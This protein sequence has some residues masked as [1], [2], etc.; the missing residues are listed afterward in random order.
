M[1][2][3]K[4]KHPNESFESL[5][6][7]F[8]RSVERDGVLQRVR[9]KEFYVKPSIRRKLAKEAARKRHLR[10]RAEEQEAMKKGN[11]NQ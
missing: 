5:N 3:A 10:E 1:P 4:Q 9:E 7:R 2:S 8:K 11:L 6:R